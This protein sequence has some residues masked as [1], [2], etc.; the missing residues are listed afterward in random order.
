MN[1]K[2]KLNRIK[3][4]LIK[5][6][7]HK[8][9]K[10]LLIIRNEKNIRD[11]MINKSVIKSKKHFIWAKNTISDKEKNIYIINIDNN[12]AGAII[13]DQIKKKHKRANWAF[14]LSNKFQNNY[15]ALVEYIFLNFFFK[16]KKFN[17]LNCVV[18]SNNQKVVNMHQKF[19]FN[20]EGEIKD[21]ILRNKTYINLYLL[22][23]NKE[24]WLVHK[25]IIDK[26]F[27]LKNYEN[28]SNIKL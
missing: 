21:Y 24:K 8:L 19:G 14:Y 5:K 7:N 4:K 9:I 6:Y 23:I 12:L 2:D 25:K 11:N 17:K 26:K 13:I 20:I 22:G 16:N 27:K 1:I 18:L 10:D 28:K 15:G 3:L